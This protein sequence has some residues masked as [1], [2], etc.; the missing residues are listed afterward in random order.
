M[1]TYALASNIALFSA[2][3]ANSSLFMVTVVTILTTVVPMSG[4]ISLLRVH[5]AIGAFH[6][7]L[8][9]MWTVMAFRAAPMML[10]IIGTATTFSA[11]RIV[12]TSVPFLF[13]VCRRVLVHS[14]DRCSRHPPPHS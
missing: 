8:V 14:R 5:A 4:L 7:L 11:T 10:S 3:S 6:L 9:T 1:R 13:S 12:S 2:L